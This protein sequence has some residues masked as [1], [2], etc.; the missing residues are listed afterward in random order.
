MTKSVLMKNAWTLAKE[1]A[2]KF[3]GKAVEYFAEALK[4]AWAIKREFD[5]Q[6]K[7]R[8]QAK[9]VSADQLKGRMTDKQ[10]NFIFKLANEIEA[11]GIDPFSVCGFVDCCGDS[12]M[13]SKKIASETIE[14]LLQA[15]KSA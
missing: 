10:R 4:E 3:G 6:K 5:A 9:K 12:Y 11:K 14:A 2:A 1:G 7:A 8:A 15:K 13:V